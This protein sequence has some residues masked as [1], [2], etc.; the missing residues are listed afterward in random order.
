MTIIKIM[1]KSY[2]Q[3]KGGEKKKI[4]GIMIYLPEKGIKIA[5]T[6][7]KNKLKDNDN[8]YNIIIII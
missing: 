6:E 4:I 3:W 1:K 2:Y 7:K 5:K 8:I